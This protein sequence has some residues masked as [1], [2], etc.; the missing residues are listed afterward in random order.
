MTSPGFWPVAGLG[1]GVGVSPV[2]LH[3]A[4]NNTRDITGINRPTDLTPTRTKAAPLKPCI[5]VTHLSF[6]GL[7]PGRQSEPIRAKS[8][9]HR[10][11]PIPPER[12]QAKPS[13]NASG[14]LA[15]IW[16]YSFELRPFK[17]YG[18]KDEKNSDLPSL[19]RRF[20]RRCRLDMANT[21]MFS[22]GPDF[23]K[24][25]ARFSDCVLATTIRRPRLPKARLS[26]WTAPV[27]GRSPPGSLPNRSRE[28]TDRA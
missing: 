18:E 27:H 11:G 26:L 22:I 23:R 28:L 3:P 17:G 9:G 2:W 5:L 13:K 4:T 14:L 1:T 15:F 20:L 12:R 8:R 10:I 24:D 21:Q 7:P 16:F 25:N 6:F 19:R